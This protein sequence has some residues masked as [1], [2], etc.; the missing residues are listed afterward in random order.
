MKIRKAIVFTLV[1]AL[2]IG[3]TLSLTSATKTNGSIDF[4]VGGVTINPPEGPCCPCVGDDPC[5]AGNGGG[6]GCKHDP[7]CDEP[8]KCLCHDPDEDDYNNFFKDNK[9]ENNLYFGSHSIREHGLFDSANTKLYNDNGLDTTD[10]GMFTG[11]EVINMS[12]E[13]F[14]MGVNVSAFYLNGSATKTLQGA[15][16]YLVAGDSQAPVNY[17]LQAGFAHKGSAVTP[18]ATVEDGGTTH[19]LSV[20][21]A[22]MVKAS[23]SGL[24][25]VVQGTAQAGKA[26]AELTWTD[27]TNTP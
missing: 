18:I 11:A 21:N 1:I 15:E 16:L 2:L 4:V 17:P 3:A 23:W 27:F 14:E 24:L 9:V 19:V 26:Q 12:G 25:D 8:C 20:P 22:N 13:L 10:V 6:G 5:D 7:D